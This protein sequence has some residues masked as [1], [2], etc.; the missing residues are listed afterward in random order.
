[1]GCKNGEA[2]MSDDII[3]DYEGDPQIGMW[4]VAGTVPAGDNGELTDYKFIQHNATTEDEMLTL[5][6][7]EYPDTTIEVSRSLPVPTISQFV[8]S[9]RVITRWMG[10]HYLYEQ[11]DTSWMKCTF[12]YTMFIVLSVAETSLDKDRVTNLY[13]VLVPSV[14]LPNN[15]SDDDRK[16]MY[17]RTGKLVA[18]ASY[19]K[20][21]TSLE[22]HQDD[23]WTYDF[24]VSLVPSPVTDTH[25]AQLK[26]VWKEN[27]IITPISNW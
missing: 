12:D 16:I 20:I 24:R 22:T 3:V 27:L 17:E 7:E 19:E 23:G 26:N 21:K 18:E 9:D 25:L 1:M 11:L 15:I 13:C 8:A 14:E 2:K 5:V 10:A 6:K 4:A